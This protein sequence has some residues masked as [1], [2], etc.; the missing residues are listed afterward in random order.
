MTNNEDTVGLHTFM[1]NRKTL[2][3]YSGPLTEDLLTQISQPVRVQLSDKETEETV[4]KRV[5]GVFIE[6][7]Q[8]IIRYSEQ[9][10]KATGESVGTIAIS[11]SG[12]GF[13]IEAVNRIDESKR[14]VLENTLMEISL[15]DQKELQEMY[16]KRLKEGPQKGSKGAELEA[17]LT[18]L[19]VS[20]NLNMNCKSLKTGPCLFIEAGSPSGLFKR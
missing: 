14:D 5:F 7:A 9:K 12:D 19:D 20:K 10:T 1:Q 13:M 17:L 6:Q 11:V 8:N 15:K 18:W 16:K 2:F 4:S 3:C